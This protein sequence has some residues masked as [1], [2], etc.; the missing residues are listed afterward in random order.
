MFLASIVGAATLFKTTTEPNLDKIK[1]ETFAI[2]EIYYANAVQTYVTANPATAGTVPQASL[3]LP[4]WYN[5]L[6]WTNVVASGV[7][8][9]YPASVSFLGTNTQ[10]NWALSAKTGNSLM[11]GVNKSGNFYN[12]ITGFN[13]SIVVPVGVPLNAPMY[14]IQTK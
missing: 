1:A 9:I 7:V 2:N 11:V 6:G 13:T 5:N 3:G 10:I 8:T 4:S 12:P 14:V